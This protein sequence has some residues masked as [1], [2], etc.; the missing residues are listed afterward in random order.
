M[1]GLELVC[2]AVLA[3]LVG[4]G[5]TCAALAVSP[6]GERSRFEALVGPLRSQMEDLEDRLYHWSRRDRKRERDQKAR[7]IAPGST[8]AQGLRARYLGDR[9]QRL[10]ALKERI[11]GVPEEGQEGGQEGS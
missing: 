10:A 5:A 3:G 8:N 9:Q 11:R 2:V 7:D 4:A 1:N 6:W